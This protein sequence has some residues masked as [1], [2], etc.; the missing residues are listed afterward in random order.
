MK[1]IIDIIKDANANGKYDIVIARYNKDN[2]TNLDNGGMDSELPEVRDILTNGQQDM[3]V[4]GYEVV[5]DG[6]VGV[7]IEGVKMLMD[8]R[9]LI[10]MMADKICWIKEA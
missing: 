9:Q 10:E 7:R 6:N 8:S 2:E 1:K 5:G 3:V 4:E